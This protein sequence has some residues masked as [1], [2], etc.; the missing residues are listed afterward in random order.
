MF[1]YYSACRGLEDID[2]LLPAEV[3]RFAGCTIVNGNLNFGFTTY[4]EFMYVRTIN[5]LCVL[6]NM[7]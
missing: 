7:F 1:V 6:A 2:P 3:P 4:D 5:L